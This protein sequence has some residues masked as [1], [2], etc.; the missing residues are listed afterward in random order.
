MKTIKQR[1]ADDELIRV[2]GMGRILHH[3][4]IQIVGIQGGF[5]ALWFDME[6]VGN[7]MENIE[8]AA[9]AARS[10]GMDSFCRIAPTDYALVTRCLE[11][12]AGGIMAAQI[13]TAEQAEEFVQ[14]SKFYPRGRRGMNTGGWDAQFATM[15]IPEFCENS[16]RESFLAIQIETAQSVEECEA[17]AAIDGVDLLF[18]GP[19]DLSLALEVPGEAMHEK[20]I[21]AVDR[22]ATACKNQG[23]HLGAVSL[24]SDHADMLVDKGCKMLSPAS[25]VKIINSGVQ[26]VKDAHAKYFK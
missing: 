5:E 8:V 20:C 2:L 24:G 16:N 23:K 7:A 11:A 17:I 19:S 10:Q 22:I 12:G 6:H 26:A 14:W 13:F 4:L 18:I 3:N 9:M 15:S 25:D 21:A 1:L